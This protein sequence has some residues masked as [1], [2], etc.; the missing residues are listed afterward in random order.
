MN[1]REWLFRNKTSVT[2]FAKKVE[3][4]RTHLNLISCGVRKPSPELAKRI[5]KATKGK[6]TKEEVLFPEDFPEK[7]E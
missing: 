7:E 3:V 1:L 4:S 2:D 6:V 5:E